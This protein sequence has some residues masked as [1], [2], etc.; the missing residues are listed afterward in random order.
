MNCGNPVIHSGDTTALC[1]D[2]G[3]KGGNHLVYHTQNFGQYY[4]KGNQGSQVKGT[5][6]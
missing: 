5:L 3:S 2:R 6:S 1:G 4:V